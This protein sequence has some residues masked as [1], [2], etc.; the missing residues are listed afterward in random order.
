[1]ADVGAVRRALDYL[2]PAALGVWMGMEAGEV[3]GT[4]LRQYLGRQT[5]MY[6]FSNGVTDEQIPLMAVKECGGGKCLRR[7]VWPLNEG[8]P[9]SEVGAVTPG[10]AGGSASARVGATCVP[11]V[12]I[13][14]CPVI[15]GAARK[16]ARGNFEAKAAAE[17]AAAG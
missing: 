8:V 1:L 12:C 6:R 14:P 4:P 11:L 13:E 16:L 10:A 9:L 5:G 15:V 7:I 2:Y 3:K 17:A